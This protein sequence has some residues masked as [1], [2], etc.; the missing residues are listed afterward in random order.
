[1]CERDA[2]LSVFRVEGNHRVPKLQCMFRENKKVGT[3]DT[4]ELIHIPPAR[5]TPPGLGCEIW[6]FMQAVGPWTVFVLTSSDSLTPLAGQWIDPRPVL[7]LLE[8]PRAGKE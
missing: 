3:D 4:Y 6:S 7:F 5:I 8:L 1:M 2:I